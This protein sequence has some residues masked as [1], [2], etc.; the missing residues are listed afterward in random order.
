M[1]EEYITIA[2]MASTK[3]KIDDIREY[4]KSINMRGTI[5][6]AIDFLYAEAES[7]KFLAESLNNIRQEYEIKLETTKKWYE[8]KEMSCPKCEYKGGMLKGEW[9]EILGRLDEDQKLI[10]KLIE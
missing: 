8:N 9:D 2:V 1:S 3:R 4:L 10:R 7:K 5:S 6:E